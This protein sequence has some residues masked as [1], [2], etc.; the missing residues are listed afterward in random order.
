MWR[1]SL[2]SQTTKVCYS[3]AGI[4]VSIWLALPLGCNRSK[5]PCGNISVAIREHP[6][7]DCE[8]MDAVSMAWLAWFI[9]FETKYHT[10]VIH[11]YTGA[12]INIYG[13]LGAVSVL[14]TQKEN[15]IQDAFFLH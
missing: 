13:S 15:K 3:S 12:R 6:Y 10:S 4:S 2:Y 5:Q 7:D 14:L 9:V 1:V 11:L 8:Q